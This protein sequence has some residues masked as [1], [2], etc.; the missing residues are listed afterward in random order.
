LKLITRTELRLGSK[1]RNRKLPTGVYKSKNKYMAVIRILSEQ[2]YL[3]HYDTPEKAH[4]A[5]LKAYNKLKE[6]FG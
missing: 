4:E 6:A 3:G 1:V 2:K 5:Y